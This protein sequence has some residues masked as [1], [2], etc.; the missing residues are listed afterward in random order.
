MLADRVAD[1]N[2]PLLGHAEGI[3]ELNY[4]PHM[5]ILANTLNQL[6]NMNTLLSQSSTPYVIVH[7]Y[8]IF[9][10][11]LISILTLQKKETVFQH[12]Y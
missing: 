3:A 6:P 9:M 12:T 11:P 10:I 4:T 8:C 5:N 1:F 7:I 2:G